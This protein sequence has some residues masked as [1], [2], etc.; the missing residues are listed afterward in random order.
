MKV[1]TEFRN[2]VENTA[3]VVGAALILLF[4]VQGANWVR[5]QVALTQQLHSWALQQQDIQRRAAQ[6]Q[7]LMPEAPNDNS[8]AGE[9]V[10]SGTTPRR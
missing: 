3:L 10:D 6:R 4:G 8:R 7:G 1:K 2:R 9:D 5:A